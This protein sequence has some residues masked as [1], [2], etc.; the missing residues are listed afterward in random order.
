MK[1]RRD[2]LK[3]SISGAVLISAGNILQSFDLKDSKLALKDDLLLRFAVVSDGH[4]GQPGTDYQQ[5]HDEM[6]A[7]LNEEHANRGTDFV[8]INGD[9]F[10]NDVVFLKQIKQHWDKL[11]APY[12]VSHGNHD[13]TSEKN[14]QS[15]WGKPWDYNFEYNKT[16]FVVLNTAD[17]TGSYVSPDATK[18]KLLLAKYQH[19]DKL[20]V[21]MHITPFKWTKGGADFPE[22]IKLLEAQKNLKAVFHG[23][24]HDEDDIK[25][26]NGRFYIFDSHIAGD[27]GTN[28]RGYRII[29][30][31]KNGDM[32]TYQMN[33]TDKRQVNSKKLG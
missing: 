31:M 7:W 6:L 24:D 32:L 23:H 28:Y 9:L 11:A 4:F 13:K 20:F 12:Y 2:F 21:F 5:K 15:V 3:L 30:L 8:F 33:P 1:S 16:G 10:H 25:I 19:L 29:E 22:T 14:W 27:W 18:T 26:N 17:E